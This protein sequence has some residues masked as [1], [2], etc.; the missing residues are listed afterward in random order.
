MRRI[1]WLSLALCFWTVPAAALVNFVIQ[2]ASQTAA[3]NADI[4]FTVSL[5]PFGTAVDGASA[6]LDFDP[7]V[8]RCQP[9]A[10]P[11]S[12]IFSSVFQAAADNILGRI[13]WTSIG[14]ATST[15]FSLFTLQCR[16]LAT[17][18]GS[19]ISFH[20]SL[21]R[22]TDASLI[23]VSVLGTKTGATVISQGNIC[24][25]F[26]PTPS[27][28]RTATP[29][30]VCVTLT[31]TRTLT[32]TVTRTPTPTPTV[33]PVYIFAIPKVGTSDSTMHFVKDPSVEFAIGCN[34][35]RQMGHADVLAG[36]TFFSTILNTPHGSCDPNVINTFD[37]FYDTAQMSVRGVLGGTDGC[38]YQLSWLASTSG[39]NALR[40]DVRMDV[41]ATTLGP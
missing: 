39:G 29:A 12:P 27:P 34:F 24:M 11:S 5:V 1:A 36:V 15:P 30:N 8:L 38:K 18:A 17:S 2:P 6:Y 7:A 3:V 32:R 22:Q 33:K 41:K 13:D 14:T 10:Q 26:T 20:A 37:T 4:T 31:P 16:V 23:G 19:A 21:P 40:C 28:S 9:P 35:S 25:P